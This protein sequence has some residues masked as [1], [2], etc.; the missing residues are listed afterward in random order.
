MGCLSIFPRERHISATLFT[1]VLFVLPYVSYS[2]VSVISLIADIVW[3][4]DLYIRLSVDFKN[5]I[6]S[7]Y[8]SVTEKAGQ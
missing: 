7:P 3:P 1:I 2:L 4:S 5:Q 8:I 6:V